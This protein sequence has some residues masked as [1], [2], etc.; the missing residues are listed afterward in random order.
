MEKYGF[1][2]LDLLTTPYILVQGTVDKLVDLEAS[3]D[4]FQKTLNVKNK[5]LLVVDNL[6][7]AIHSE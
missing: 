1:Y 7:H 2:N 4:F 5:T 3:F 6:W